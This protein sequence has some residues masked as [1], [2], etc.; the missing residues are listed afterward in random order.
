M[1]R[2]AIL[3][4]SRLNTFSILKPYQNFDFP[5]VLK[6]SVYC[7]L[8][9]KFYILAI[10]GCIIHFVSQRFT[11]YVELE[12]NHKDHQSLTLCSAQDNPKNYIM[13]LSVVQTLLGRCQF[14]CH[15]HFN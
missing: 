5:K 13:C 1:N 4:F 6:T 11:K 10:T 9:Q 2:Y 3:K 14:W 15:D 8:I 12:G 7:T